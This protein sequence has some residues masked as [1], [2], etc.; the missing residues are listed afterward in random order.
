[1]SLPKLL[2]DIAAIRMKKD[3]TLRKTIQRSLNGDMIDFLQM[4]NKLSWKKKINKQKQAKNEFKRK[5]LQ[6][7]YYYSFQ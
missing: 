7:S 4:P 6:K 2:I 5:Q 3:I 1:M